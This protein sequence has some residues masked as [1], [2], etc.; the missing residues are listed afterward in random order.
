MKLLLEIAKYH[1]AF[2]VILDC[3]PELKTFY[4]RAG[5]TEAA[6]QCSVYLD[7]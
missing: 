1:K 7:N 4:E 6:I 5:L 2:K 3:K